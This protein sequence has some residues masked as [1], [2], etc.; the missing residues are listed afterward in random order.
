MTEPTSLNKMKAQSFIWEA[1]T[2]VETQLWSFAF[3]T[4]FCACLCSCVF[5][6][7]AF[8]GCVQGREC[9]PTDIW[10]KRFESEILR[11]D[12]SLGLRLS[13]TLGHRTTEQ[14][15]GGCVKQMQCQL[16]TTRQLGVNL[17]GNCR[18]LYWPHYDDWISDNTWCTNACRTSK[19]A[20]ILHTCTVFLLQ[21]MNVACMAKVTSIFWTLFGV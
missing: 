11:S 2:S 5:M 3:P 1:Q 14:R 15:R 12:N 7:A 13:V 19:C 4:S 21:N 8:S 9:V 16:E 6:L 18:I 20:D 17:N 10:V